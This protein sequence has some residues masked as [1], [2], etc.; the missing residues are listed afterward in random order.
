MKQ[1]NIANTSKGMTPDQMK[2]LAAENLD[3]A[4]QAIAAYN[5]KW[6]G[7]LSQEECRDLVG[8]TYVKAVESAETFDPEKASIGTWIGRIAHN[9]AFDYVQKR[10]REVP[11]DFDGINACGGEDGAHP[12]G[13]S[14][15]TFSD[16]KMIAGLSQEEG[17]LSYEAPRRAKLQKECWRAAYS[18]LSDKEQ[19][20][21]YMRYDLHKGGEEMAQELG[22]THGALRTA[23]SRAVD[24]FQEQLQL[25]HYKEIDEWTWRYFGDEDIVDLDEEDEEEFFFGSRS[26]TNG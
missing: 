16:R 19:V 12:G 26:E 4:E 3:V 14:W 21:L 15:L 10:L 18:R 24:A 8:I 9:A 5:R 17:N 22:M 23:L 13:P 2:Y 25:L 7:L 1:E 11:T 6:R 20:L